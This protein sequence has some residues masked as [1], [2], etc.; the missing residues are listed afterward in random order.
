M[1]K[2]CTKCKKSYP[3]TTEYFHKEPRVK[4][5]LAARCKNCARK[6]VSEWA[7][8]TGYYKHYR[9]PPGSRKYRK[10]PEARRRAI[11]SAKKYKKENPQK[12]AL[13]N[14]RYAAKN[15]AL[16]RKINERSKAKGRRE[17]G[18]SYMRSLILGRG[19][20]KWGDI[21]QELI[22]LKRVQ[23]Q[24]HRKIKEARDG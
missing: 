4:S 8:R 24:L 19:G 9:R 18:D 15:K 7:H 2:K 11:E 10:C 14:K 6:R 13:Y 17:L 20:I 12:V 3:A 21:P 5:G 16:V 23:I 1:I 22:E